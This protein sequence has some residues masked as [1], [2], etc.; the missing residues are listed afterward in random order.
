MTIS[1]HLVLL[2]LP[3]NFEEISLQNSYASSH[4]AISNWKSSSQLQGLVLVGR[5]MN[6]NFSVHSSSN[7]WFSLSSFSSEL[8]TCYFSAIYS[9]Y[10]WQNVNMRTV[11]KIWVKVKHCAHSSEWPSCLCIV[12]METSPGIHVPTQ[13]QHMATESSGATNRRPAGRMRPIEDHWSI[14]LR[15]P[16]NR[17]PCQCGYF[18]W[19]KSIQKGLCL[20]PTSCILS[21]HHRTLK[22]LCKHSHGNKPTMSCLYPKVKLIVVMV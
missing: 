1:V 19:S 6:A 22:S 11:P 17:Y 4:N 21:V 3:L 13:P 18:P 14:H 12:G 15:S 20:Y 16:W 2:F 5:R 8:G 10:S 7:C 9:S